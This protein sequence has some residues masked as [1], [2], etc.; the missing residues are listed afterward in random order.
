MKV[1]SADIRD[2][3]LKTTRD[4]LRRKGLKGWNMDLLAQETGLAKNTLYKIIGSK[5]QL[6]TQ[7]ILSKMQ[8]DLVQIEQ[9]LDEEN[10]YNL[11]V[12]RITKRFAELVKDSFDN[13]IPSIYLE[14]PAIEKNVRTAQIEIHAS[15]RAFILKGMEQGM[16]RNDVAP[17]F[18]LNLVEGI[19]LHYYRTGH[20]GDTFE[21]A[22]HRA[23]DCLVNGLRKT[24]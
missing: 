17:E 2:K 6:L 19:V 23:M 5:E 21:T 1:S 16:M 12:S 22:F 13:V 3:V 20:T 11:A 14:Y 15:L 9:I 7:A 10:D 8:E 4:L 24:Q 18:I